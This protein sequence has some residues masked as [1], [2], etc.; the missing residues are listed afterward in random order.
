MRRNLL[1]RLHVKY[2]FDANVQIRIAHV[3]AWCGSCHSMMTQQ[4]PL[5]P[6]TWTTK[7]TVVS[8]TMA[9]RTLSLRDG[10][11]VEGK[12]KSTSYIFSLSAAKTCGKFYHL[13]IV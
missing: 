11:M 2:I 7:R 5:T 10:N 3:D 4:Q 8:T 13:F 1:F 9:V 6:G 12:E